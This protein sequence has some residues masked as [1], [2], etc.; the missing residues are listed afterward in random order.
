MPVIQ[1]MWKQC[2]K[3]KEVSRQKKKKSASVPVKVNVKVPAGWKPLSLGQ[4]TVKDLA[5]QMFTLKGTN[6]FLNHHF[7][8]P[9][10]SDNCCYLN[11]FRAWTLAIWKPQCNTFP[12]VEI[13]ENTT[14]FVSWCCK[15]RANT[16]KKVAR[17][18]VALILVSCT[19]SSNSCGLVQ[20]DLNLS[21]LS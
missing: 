7:H 4:R 15:P 3:K 14:W 18:S 10:I 19:Y 17:L 13:F 12:A 20:F 11:S 16:T 5:G 2:C 8:P 6:L 9:S 1:G 21:S